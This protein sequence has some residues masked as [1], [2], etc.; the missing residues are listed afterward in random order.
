MALTSRRYFPTRTLAQLVTALEDIEHELL[1]G[2]VTDSW[3]ATDAAA[4]KWID[5]SLSPARRREMVLH[6]LGILDPTTY[7]PRTYARIQRTVPTY[8]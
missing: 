6:D 7:P 1:T 3:N 5:V 4:H 8:I 2:K